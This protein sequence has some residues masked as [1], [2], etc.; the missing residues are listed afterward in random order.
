MGKVG[1]ARS[2]QCSSKL[3]ECGIRIPVP[4]LIC[5]QVILTSCVSLRLTSLQVVGTS[6][7]ALAI[8]SSNAVGAVPLWCCHRG[9]FG[10]LSQRRRDKREQRQG[11]RSHAEE[12][13]QQCDLW[14]QYQQGRADQLVA[15]AV[16]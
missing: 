7:L 12:D 3:P 16:R 13:A 11:E 9:R 6:G 10:C 2:L 15:S 4:L 8:T 1:F 5:T 14:G